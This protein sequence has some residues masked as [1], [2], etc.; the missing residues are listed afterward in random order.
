MVN[1]EWFKQR[2]NF[3][4]TYTV[5]TEL[6]YGGN[7]S[8]LTVPIFDPA[9]K[10]P[11]PGNVIPSSRFDP[12]SVKLLAFYPKANLPTTSNNYQRVGSAPIN[13]D[14]FILR[15]DFVESSKSQWTAA[16]AGAMRTSRIPVS[17]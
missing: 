3:N 5:P 6:Q 13:K 8:G 4:G 14:Q 10:A 11:F 9:S 7:F 16:T 1:N 15:L 2:R 17:V 12:I